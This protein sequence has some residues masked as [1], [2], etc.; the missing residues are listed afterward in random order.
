[1]DLS[2]NKFNDFIKEH[3]DDDPLKLRLRY[4]GPQPEWMPLALNHLECLRRRGGKFVLDGTDYSPRIFPSRVSMEQSSSARV[5]RFNASIV[6]SGSSVLDMTMGMGMDAR[7]LAARGCV[8]TAYER[9]AQLAEVSAYNF[10][11]EPNVTVVGGDSVSMLGDTDR[12]WDVIFIDPA[13][14]DGADTRFYNLHDCTPDLVDIMPLIAGHAPRMI[15]KLSPML[16]VTATLRDLPGTRVLYVVEDG[17]ECKELL[18]DVRTGGYNGEPA[19]VIVGRSEFSFTPSDERDSVGD[20][21]VPRVGD[22]IYEPSAATMKAAPFN[23]LCTRLGL[24]ALSANTHVY[25]SDQK[26]DGFPGNVYRLTDMLPYASG[27]IKRFAANY[28]TVAEVAVRNFGVSAD[29]L[30]TKLKVRAKGVQAMAGA[31]TRLLGVTDCSNTRHMLLLAAV[32][33]P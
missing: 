31:P 17:G 10:A 19:I 26:I 24:K 2:D 27:V 28:P 3:T 11:D 33:R 18:A 4:T 29:T 30:R 23:L 12:R 9:N 22:Y 8:V 13:R 32:P 20:Y 1:M 15:A 25:F 6:P 14:R 5:A 16:D 21:G 7:M